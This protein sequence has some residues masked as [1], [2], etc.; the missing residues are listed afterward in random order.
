MSKAGAGCTVG[1]T[2]SS[3]MRILAEGPSRRSEIEMNR[4]VV[5]TVDGSAT[6]FPEPWPPWLPLCEDDASYA[7]QEKRGLDM[8]DRMPAFDSSPAR[9]FWGRSRG[10]VPHS[11]TRYALSTPY[12]DR[13]GIPAAFSCARMPE[14]LVMAVEVTIRPPPSDRPMKH[15]SRRP[16]RHTRQTASLS[17][18]TGMT[19]QRKQ[20]RNTYHYRWLSVTRLVLS[21]TDSRICDRSWSETGVTWQYDRNFDA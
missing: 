16:A 6:A 4:V 19:S 10:W 2:I 8:A 3:T 13:A 14:Y 15:V 17:I 5:A 18:Y 11:I 21:H 12:F 7:D 9:V 1:W 20:V